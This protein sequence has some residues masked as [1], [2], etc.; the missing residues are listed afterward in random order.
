MFLILS[1]Q[2]SD[3][4]ATY[5][6]HLNVPALP[7]ALQFNSLHLLSIS[8]WCGLRRFFFVCVCHNVHLSCV[9]SCSLCLSS[10]TSPPSQAPWV[11]FF[12]TRCPLTFLLSLQ[13]LPSALQS[14]HCL[15]LSFLCLIPVSGTHRHSILAQIYCSSASPLKFQSSSHLQLDLICSCLFFLGTFIPVYHLSACLPCLC[16]FNCSGSTSEKVV[17]PLDL[18]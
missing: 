16:G 14:P 13:I 9:H 17:C 11:L 4:S 8:I 15:H 1:D 5:L 10:A 7:A 12:T 3:V 2:T 18:M 6:L